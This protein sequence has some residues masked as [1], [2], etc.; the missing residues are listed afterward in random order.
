MVQNK[1]FKRLVRDR[2]RKTGES[3]TAARAQLQKRNGTAPSLPAQVAP[4]V[5]YA[6]LG[7][8]SDAIMK[9][10][11]ERT[12]REW[13]EALD[14]HHASKLP[15]REIAQIVSRE[16][17][18]ADW[19]SQ[20]VTVGYERIKGLRAIGQRRDGSYEASKSR[21]YGVTVKTLFGAWANA[22]TR[23]RW[24]S[25]N[26]VKVRSATAPKAIRLSWADGTVVIV[27]F[28]PKGKGKSAV[29]VAHTRLPSRAAADALKKYWS[30]RL[31]ALGGV[32]TAG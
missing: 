9:A 21:T 24:L 26:G 2:M 29:A 11:T 25:E 14:W 6:A 22:N 28:L 27:G 18:V 16:F 4:A 5:D 12:W 7:G 8:K 32:L 19:W 13:V 31:D 3:Y 30:E 17:G 10:K 1:D 15:H 23:R 20:T